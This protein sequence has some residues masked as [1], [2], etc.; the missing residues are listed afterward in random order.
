MVSFVAASYPRR[1]EP[2]AGYQA[3]Q[4]KEPPL[5]LSDKWVGSQV[6]QTAVIWAQEHTDNTAK[7]GTAASFSYHVVFLLFRRTTSSI[8]L[9]NFESVMALWCVCIRAR[10]VS[11]LPWFFSGKGIVSLSLLRR[12][13]ISLI[14]LQWY[15]QECWFMLTSLQKKLVWLIHFKIHPSFNSYFYPQPRS[16]EFTFCF[17][18]FMLAQHEQKILIFTYLC[19]SI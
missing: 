2:L 19:S 12:F 18:W 13:F 1:R 4:P 3:T 14:S 8:F 7:S 9:M 16:Q 5:P 10:G 11:F 6:Q 17:H 15:K